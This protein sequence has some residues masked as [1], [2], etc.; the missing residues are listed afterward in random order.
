MPLREPQAREVTGVCGTER[1]VGQR[2]ARASCRHEIFEYIQPL[3][4]VGLDRELHR[5]AVR[6]EHE[7]A[8]T[9]ELSHL[10]DVSSR[11][12]VHH[13]LDSVVLVEVLLE[14]FDNVRRRLF[15]D[16]D[17][18][19]VPLV[20]GELAACEVAVDVLDLLVRLRNERV[21]FLGDHDV[22]DGYRDRRPR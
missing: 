19:R 5:L 4:E 10:R 20:L 16:V 11:S 1:R 22:R 9:G 14:R 17:D 15:P 3:A 2:L 8:H 6:R 12:G 18:A 13:H 7:S 21:F